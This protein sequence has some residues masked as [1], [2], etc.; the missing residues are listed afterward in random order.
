M[1][2]TTLAR[3]IASRSRSLHLVQCRLHSTQ[4][5]DVAE[6][7][8]ARPEISQ[9]ANMMAIG[10]RRIF[11]EEHDAFRETCRK[12]YAEHIVPHSGAGGEW[13]QQ[14]HISREAWLKAGEYGLLG[15]NCPEAY[16]G[17]GAS[18]LEA[19]I[20]WE[21]C[22]YADGSPSGPGFALHSDIC[23]P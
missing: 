10:N 6:A 11:T 8:A 9:A 15:I 2:G 14:Q 22:M 23:I 5:I 7:A 3:G 18:I 12:F 20:S 21:E 17:L 19:A 1:R 4:A 13:E 16:G